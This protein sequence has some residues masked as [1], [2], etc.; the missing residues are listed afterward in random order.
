M[1]LEFRLRLPPLAEQR[2]IA[3]VLDKANGLRTI[4]RARTNALERFVRSA[5]LEF[6]GDP[7]RNERN[8]PVGVASSAIATIDA[9]SSVSGEQRPRGPNE[10]A[11]LKI[12]AVTSGTYLPDE[13]KV[14]ARP[15]DE[16]V[17]PKRGDLLFSR[18]NT[19]E[20]VAATCLVHV[21]VPNLFIP[22]KLWRITP[23]PDL[24]EATYLRYLLA[25]PGFRQSLTRQATGTSGSM[26]N[27]SQDK[28]LR[29]E[30]PLPPLDLQ[31]RFAALAW[32]ALDVRDRAI[33]AADLAGRADGVT[34]RK[35]SL[36][37]PAA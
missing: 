24:A 20:L 12:S 18:A 15:P 33:G 36:H 14:V 1:L 28:L 17:T 4:S 26:L 29:Q 13:C 19:R 23:N 25:D 34:L 10:W 3:S 5:F 6:F 37:E 9:G 2:R 22:D 31:R 27:V 11:V 21:T 32:R 16:P 30:V 35:S 8:W 7:V